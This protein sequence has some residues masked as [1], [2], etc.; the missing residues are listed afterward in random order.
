[1][2]LEM[3]LG[4]HIFYRNNV[5]YLLANMLY[6]GYHWKYI[7][8]LFFYQNYEINVGVG[9]VKLYSCITHL[10][11]KIISDLESWIDTN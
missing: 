7:H 10:N 4:I 6:H 8:I 3:T 1:V 2:D 5:L 11:E 9:I